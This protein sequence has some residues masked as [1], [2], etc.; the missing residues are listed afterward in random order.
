MARVPV[1]QQGQPLD[2]AYIS[3]LATAVNQL[4]EEGAVLAQGNNF[5]LKGRLNDTPSSYKLYGAQIM[6][7]EIIFVAG[8]S[9]TLEQNVSFSPYNFASPPIVVA[10]LVNPSD[11]EANV[12]LKNITSG[13]ATVLVKFPTS[14]N[15]SSSVSIMAVG[16]PSSTS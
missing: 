14:Q 11:T 12:S 3:T 8:T 10:T 13:S 9:D 4:S 2:L 15:N 1:P 16:I 7:Q 6:A 5:I